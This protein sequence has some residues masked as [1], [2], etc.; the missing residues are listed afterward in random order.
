MTLS[1]LLSDPL[2]GSL[3]SLDAS[4]RG[5]IVAACFAGKEVRQ[6]WETGLEAMFTVEFSMYNAV[7][8]NLF[9]A[10]VS[11]NEEIANFDQ[12][13]V[14]YKVR[15]PHLSQPVRIVI[16][17]TKAPMR[18]SDVLFDIDMLSVNRLGMY[19]HTSDSEILTRVPVPLSIV[20]KNCHE[21]TY[22]VLSTVDDD[23]AVIERMKSM[24]ELGFSLRSSKVELES[25]L[26]EDKCPICQSSF[27]AEGDDAAGRRTLRTSCGHHFHADCWEKHVNHSVETNSRSASTLGGEWS[28]SSPSAVG[29]VFINC[30]M[31]REGYRSWE[32]IL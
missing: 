12:R 18:C 14:R 4:V 2:V 28:F 32:C 6:F 10:V 27:F 3:L 21:H 29:A 15:H 16:V 17:Y 25:T 23:C 30:P 9:P 5:T 22:E 20:L 13:K 31:C 26:P 8:R 19:I 24:K 1:S 7:E 11:R